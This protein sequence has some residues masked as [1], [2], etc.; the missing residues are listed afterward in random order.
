MTEAT[1]VDPIQAFK[2]AGAVDV[3]IFLAPARDPNKPWMVYGAGC[4]VDL[5]EFDAETIQTWRNQGCLSSA[6]SVTPP[7]PP[8]P[9]I[10]G[11]TA[12]PD[13]ADGTLATIAWTT[14]IDA[15]SQVQYGLTETYDLS[16][17]L[18]SALVTDHSVALTGLTAATTYHF[19]ASSGGVSSADGTFVTAAA[20]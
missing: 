12:T 19:A 8:A 14:D 11:V 1:T 10:S 17:S 15:D 6:T 4:A 7:A 9:V 2:D 3:A 13:A 18:D 5:A 20:A 16:S